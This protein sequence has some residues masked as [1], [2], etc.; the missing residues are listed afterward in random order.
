MHHDP[1]DLKFIVKE[2]KLSKQSQF[3]P[4]INKSER[5]IFA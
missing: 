5:E 2:W 4:E 1:V 3:H